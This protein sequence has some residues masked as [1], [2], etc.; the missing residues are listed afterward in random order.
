MS[1]ASKWQPVHPGIK[2]EKLWRRAPGA[3]LI[4]GTALEYDSPVTASQTM[5]MHLNKVA[6][7]L[8]LQASHN[9]G[10]LGSPTPSD[11]VVSVPADL[12]ACAG[13]EHDLP[14][15]LHC[16]S[17]DAAQHTKRLPIAQMS[18]SSSL[19]KDYLSSGTWQLM[20]SSQPSKGSNK[21]SKG[22]S[23]PMKGSSQP[24][25]GSSQSLLGSDR[26]EKAAPEVLPA[27]VPAAK[28]SC[29]SAAASRGPSTGT[30]PPSV[31]IVPASTALG[32]ELLRR[33]DC[34]DASHPKEECSCTPAG[35]VLRLLSKGAGRLPLG[36]IVPKR[37][38]TLSD[39][40]FAVLWCAVPC[41]A[42]LYH[43]WRCMNDQLAYS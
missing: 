18:A 27:A 40:F 31:A 6:W 5:H 2:A 1:K 34:G 12:A 23:Q 13:L 22:I 3:T 33:S 14:A 35:E 30:V 20:G 43:E 39:T 24:A 16:E 29:V 32:P 25:K 10:Q 7:W 11:P 42:A 26:P 28:D 15:V 4:P 17:G 21:P 41:C 9:M 38:A 36:C 37:C 19:P 8:D